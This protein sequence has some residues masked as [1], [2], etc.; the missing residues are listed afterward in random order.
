MPAN[1]PVGKVDK[2]EE[3]KK[4]TS[5]FARNILNE[6]SRIYLYY[7]HALSLLRHEYIILV[8]V[9]AE[10]VCVFCS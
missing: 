3:G 7:R 6:L 5:L 9:S 8:R 2:M 1:Q 4:T 10:H